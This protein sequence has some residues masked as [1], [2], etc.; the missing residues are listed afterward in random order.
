MLREKEKEDST[1][2]LNELFSQHDLSALHLNQFLI[3]VVNDGLFQ[4]FLLLLCHS[5]WVRRW[6]VGLIVQWAELVGPHVSNGPTCSA[7]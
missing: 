4:L 5:H 6:G 1:L 3:V 2:P 7:L